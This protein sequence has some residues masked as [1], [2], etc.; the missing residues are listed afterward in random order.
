MPLVVGR[1]TSADIVT[2]RL[3]SLVACLVVVGVLLPSRA[4]ARTYYC[5]G[6]KATIVGTA[7]FDQLKGTRGPDVIV[8]LGGA[9]GINGRGGRDRICTG[10]GG[11]D[12][13]FNYEAVVGAGGNDLISGGAGRENLVGGPGNDDVRG[14]PGSD[15]LGDIPYTG[16]DRLAGGRGADS[17]SGGP[18]DDDLIGGRGADLLHPGGGDDTVRGGR[19]RAR[20]PRR[21]RRGWG[22]GELRGDPSRRQR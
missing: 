1:R 21:N 15:W 6:M 11:R 2:H 19:E 7:G 9:D 8:G 17:L 12:T 4:Q 10:R 16:N 13:E 5:F 18:G 3:L 20:F 22:L 14:G